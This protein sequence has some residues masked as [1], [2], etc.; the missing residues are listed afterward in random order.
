MKHSF[1]PKSNRTSLHGGV[2][3]EALVSILILSIG[4]LGMAG[5]Q[6]NAQSFQKTSW[7]V[8]RISEL[9]TDISEK[10]RS[11]P[12]AADNGL[13]IYSKAYNTSRTETFTLTGC[14]TAGTSCTISQKAADDIA[15]WVTK[16][17]TSIPQ[18]SALLTGGP[19][20][21][22]V[23]TLM[24]LDKESTGSPNTCSA[25]GTESG[26]EW[27]NCCPSVASTSG[28]TGLKCHRALFKP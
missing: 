21:G 17:Q 19:T 18:G 20:A 8:H 12:T 6:V 3:I 10:V 22:F 4:L 26:V 25:A 7:I 28:I 2:L 11:N 23:I 13:Y 14:D 5:L 16:A 9:V 15:T 24:W 27:R 1:R